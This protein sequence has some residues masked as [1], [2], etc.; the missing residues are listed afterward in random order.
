MGKEIVVA[1]GNKHKILE[2]SEI[3]SPLG[4]VVKGA[5]EVGGMPDVVED[6]DTFE[7][8]ASK[9]AVEAAKALG[10]MVLADDSGLEVFALNGEPGV[11]SARYAGEGGNDGRNLAKLLAKMDGM[12]ERA[13]RFVCVMAVATPEGL[14]GTAEGEVRGRIALAPAGNGGFGYDP[15]FIPDGYDRTFGELPPEVKNSL[16]HRSNAL[17]NAIAMKLL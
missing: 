12:T 6:A 10:R 7:G 3:L 2:I 8:N 16:S 5:S 17:K 1:T 13:A 11:Y 9:K 4:Y 14:V 15:A